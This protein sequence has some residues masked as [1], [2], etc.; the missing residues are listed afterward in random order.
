V[1][2]AH[3]IR[4]QSVYGIQP[5]AMLKLSCRTADIR[6]EWTGTPCHFS[7]SKKTT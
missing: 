2:G 7:G 1:G 4:N 3:K 6:A 5:S